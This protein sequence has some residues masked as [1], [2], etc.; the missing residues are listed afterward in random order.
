M[1]WREKMRY[2][3]DEGKVSSLHKDWLTVWA[4]MEE[5]QLLKEVMARRDGHDAEPIIPAD[6][7][8]E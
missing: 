2:V 5:I 8:G 6:E 4:A 7:V 1:E 3:E